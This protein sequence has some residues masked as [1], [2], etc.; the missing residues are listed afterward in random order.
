MV[1]LIDLRNLL[2]MLNDQQIQVV[3]LFV[4]L[5]VLI[6]DH[7][8]LLGQVVQFVFNLLSFYDLILDLFVQ[9][10]NHLGVVLL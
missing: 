1:E 10:F 9:P 8:Y 6:L 4:G 5:L 3:F 2:P 7:V